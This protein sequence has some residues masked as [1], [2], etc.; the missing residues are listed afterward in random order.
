LAGCAHLPVAQALEGLPMDLSNVPFCPGAPVSQ[1]SASER[2][3]SPHLALLRVLPLG[4][5]SLPQRAESRR[6]GFQCAAWDSPGA[7]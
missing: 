5:H 6:F 1:T 3:A 2:R 4:R 7:R